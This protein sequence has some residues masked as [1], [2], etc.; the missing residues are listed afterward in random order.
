MG[1]RLGLLM[2]DQFIEGLTLLYKLVG[3]WA[4]GEPNLL[5]LI[6]IGLGW[7]KLWRNLGVLRLF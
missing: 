4:G 7:A 5:G 3:N 1:G 2:G 6:I